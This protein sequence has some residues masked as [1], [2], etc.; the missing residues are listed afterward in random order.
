M[1]KYQCDLCYKIFKQKID[2]IR[3]I[4]RQTP[5]YSN[6][7]EDNSLI[8]EKS[9]DVNSNVCKHCFKLF[10][11]K[12]NKNKH[13]KL[14]NC[15]NKKKIIEESSEYKIKLL[16]EENKI[17]KLS[18]NN[19]VGITIP[20]NKIIIPEIE[21]SPEYIYLLHEREFVN[22]K[23]SIYKIGKSKQENLKR[24]YQYPKGDK[25]EMIND[26]FNEIMKIV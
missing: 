12:T 9:M 22:S 14:G 8:V 26:I 21:K 25:N 4:E 1:T 3:H 20:E 19:V 7:K 16:E 23:Q 15:V 11:T 24:L 5:C 13:E 2:Y 10:S 17:L 18:S 6:F